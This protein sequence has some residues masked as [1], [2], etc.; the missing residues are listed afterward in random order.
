MTRFLRHCL[1][2]LLATFLA[3]YPIF[4]AEIPQGNPAE[5]GFSA[6]RLAKIQPAMQALVDSGKFAGVLT[7]I[8]RKGKIVHFETAGFA[9]SGIE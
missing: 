6:E 9:G 3:L 2:A 7:L 4:A 1:F 5:L 8:A